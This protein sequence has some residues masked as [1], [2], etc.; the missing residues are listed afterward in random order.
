MTGAG[1]DGSLPGDTSP[2]QPSV[3]RLCFFVYGWLSWIGSSCSCAFV[4][5]RAHL[6]NDKVLG[7]ADSGRARL[8]DVD[9]AEK[10]LE[11]GTKHGGVWAPG[12]REAGRRVSKRRRGR[13]V[14][15]A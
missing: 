7:G 14:K 12:T 3:M 2:A 8:E 10:G 15:G 1:E 9:R 5:P 13:A 11:L 6:A 4:W